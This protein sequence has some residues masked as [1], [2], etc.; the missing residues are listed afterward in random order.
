MRDPGPTAFDIISI[1]IWVSWSR[2]FAVQMVEVKEFNG[3]MDSFGFK[4][5]LFKSLK[6][7]FF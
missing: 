1:V 7:L 5:R 4:T 2:D 6:A 3:F